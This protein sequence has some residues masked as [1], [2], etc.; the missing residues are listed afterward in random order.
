M[1][2]PSL[3]PAQTPQG[4][5]Q[6]I[7]MVAPSCPITVVAYLEWSLAGLSIPTSTSGWKVQHESQFEQ[8]QRKL[9]PVPY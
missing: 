3:P 9:N 5:I 6:A 8:V 7:P 4:P 1:L 2:L